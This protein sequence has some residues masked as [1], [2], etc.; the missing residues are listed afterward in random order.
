MRVIVWGIN[1][2]PEFTG[3]APHNVA[4]CEYLRTHGHDVEMVTSFPYYPNWRKHTKDLGKLYR[5]DSINA[6]PV[7]RCWHFVPARVSAL[8]RILHEGSFV[9]TSTFRALF[10]PRPDVYVVVSPPLLL[11]VAA[12]FVGKLKRAPFVFHVQD[13]QPDAAV[14]LGML[15]QNWFTR[16]LYGLEAFAYR[17]AARVSGITRGMLAAFKS[18]GVPESKLIYFPNAIDLGRGEVAPARGEFRKREGFA[19]DDFLAVYAGNLGVKQG[20][21]VLL[22]TAAMVNDQRIR[23]LICGDGAQ[24]EVLA[25]RAREMKLPNFSM[26]PLQAGPDYPAL[27]VDADVCFITQQSGAGN[28][29][30]PSKLLGLLA[31]SKPVVTVAAPECELAL[32]L[33]EGNFGVNVPPGQPR[34]LAA[35]LDA[36]AKDPQKLA[37][38]GAAGRRYVEQFEKS[39]VLENFVDELAGVL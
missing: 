8:K 2:A 38:Y 13:M 1:Y 31:A 3:I 19:E 29:F 35:V 34:E 9:F 32:A 24:R 25:A 7:L 22:E 27:L 36:L 20:L 23:F 11:G 17:H 16:V 4:L 15:K 18:K 28:S 30:F 39:R 10:L 21:E 12:W 14:G 37:E 5:A 33:R 26:L 6:V